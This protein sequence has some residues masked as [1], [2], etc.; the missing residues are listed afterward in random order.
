MLQQSSFMDVE[1][2]GSW[3]DVSNFIDGDYTPEAVPYHHKPLHSLYPEWHIHASCR[4][5]ADSEDVFFDTA[6]S[7]YTHS[8]AATAREICDSCPV[9]NDC[10]AYA[11]NERE[12]YGFWAGT[13]MRQRRAIFKAINQGLT[14]AAE[15]IERLSK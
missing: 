14:T 11:I 1:S 12:E 10:L 7:N 6:G 8:D 13:T 15:E 3:V 5:T 4:G 2:K 9:F